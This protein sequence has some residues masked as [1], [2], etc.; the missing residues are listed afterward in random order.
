MWLL[1]GHTHDSARR[2][3]ERSICVSL[4]AWELRPA[5]AEEIAAETAR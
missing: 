5:S 1:H 4:E 2:S 3:G